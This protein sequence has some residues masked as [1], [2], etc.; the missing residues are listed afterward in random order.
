MACINLTGIA[1]YHPPVAVTLPNQIIFPWCRGRH[2]SERKEHTRLMHRVR[3]GVDFIN[4]N[5]Q[6]LGLGESIR[7][8]LLGQDSSRPAMCPRTSGEQEQRPRRTMLPYIDGD[9]SSGC[10][11][12]AVAP[13]LY[14]IWFRR[15]V[16]HGGKRLRHLT[17]GCGYVG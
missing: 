11:G 10:V 2:E 13:A 7:H 16:L 15:H 8:L 17:S 1:N 4:E 5:G 12:H 9:R 6:L 3:I 14:S